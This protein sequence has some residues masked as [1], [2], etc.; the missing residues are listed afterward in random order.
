MAINAMKI[1]SA[2]ADSTQTYVNHLLQNYSHNPN[3]FL[4]KASYICVVVMTAAFARELFLYFTESKQAPNK[5]KTQFTDSTTAETTKKAESFTQNEIVFPHPPEDFHSSAVHF[6]MQKQ[7]LQENPIPYFANDLTQNEDFQF[8]SLHQ[9]PE[10]IEPSGYVHFTAID[11]TKK[12]TQMEA[13]DS[14]IE[15]LGDIENGRRLIL[16]DFQKK[17][18]EL[19]LPDVLE[20]R[21]SLSAII[22][23][24]MYN[25][26]DVLPH[27]QMQNPG[28][29]HPHKTLELIKNITVNYKE[30]I[31]FDKKESLKNWKAFFTTANISVTTSEA[32]S[33]DVHEIPF[34]STTQQNP[35]ETLSNFLDSQ[36]NK[37]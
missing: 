13:L 2:A 34:K 24:N 16:A 23:K 14:L 15:D 9:M 10:I 37:S 18:S 19:G 11:S 1:I 6:Q 29:F 20:D 4:L 27:A 33:L 5:L 31:I 8:Q 35:T 28:N 12:Q 21:L 32:A 30:I 3:L 22:C 17:R 36:Q 25:R 7:L 26:T